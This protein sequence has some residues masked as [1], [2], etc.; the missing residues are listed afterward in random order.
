MTS[1]LDTILC[2]AETLWIPVAYD[3]ADKIDGKA[4]FGTPTAD[5]RQAWAAAREL[6][7][8]V[9]GCGFTVR[10]ADPTA[11]VDHGD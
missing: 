11:E 5:R 2:A 4:Y 3:A 8:S 1:P 9:D 7:E 6:C 10:R